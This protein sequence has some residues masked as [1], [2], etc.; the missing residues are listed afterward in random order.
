MSDLSNMLELASQMSVALGGEGT[1]IL[2]RLGGAYVCADSGPEKF[3][4]YE[5]Q[6]AGGGHHRGSTAEEALL[7]VIKTLFANL[8]PH[9]ERLS[10]LLCTADRLLAEAEEYT[11]E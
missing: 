11:S 10:N 4:R 7:Q 6:A 5:A 9:R 2:K 8:R 3:L 1:V